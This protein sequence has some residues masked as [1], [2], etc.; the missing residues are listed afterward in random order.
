MTTADWAIVISIG[1][2]FIALASFVWNV[3]SKFIFP[4]SRVGVDIAIMDLVS[5]RGLG[6]SSI[7]MSA[8]NLGPSEVVINLAVARKAKRWFQRHHQIA[9]LNPL[10]DFPRSLEDSSGPFSGELPKKLA[11]GETLSVH[12]PVAREWFSQEDLVGF[13]FTDTFGRRHWASAAQVKRLRRSVLEN[14]ERNS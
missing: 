14:Q 8:T 7:T 13:G 3:W 1:S 6:P 11:A 2:I 5:V 9:Y 4:K 10:S 12:F